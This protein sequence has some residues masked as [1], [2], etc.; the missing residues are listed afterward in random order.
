MARG[1]I[2]ATGIIRTSQLLVEPVFRLQRLPQVYVDIILEKMKRHVDCTVDGSVERLL[3]HAMDV[4]LGR[5]KS[6]RKNPGNLLL[7]GT[8]P[9]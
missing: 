5:G 8:E 6:F 2:A 1:I 7:Q 9:H 3:P 4:R